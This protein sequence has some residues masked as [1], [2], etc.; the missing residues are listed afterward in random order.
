[1]P[2]P[3]WNAQG[4]VPPIDVLAPASPVRSPYAVPLKEFV[5]KYATSMERRS[6]LRG[7]LQYRL[8][9]H[10]VGLNE[11]F[12]WVNGSF[13]EEVEK[14]EGRP[15]KD[16]DVVTFFTKTTHVDLALVGDLADHA[17]VKQTYKVDGYPLELDLL[18][19]SEIVAHS[20]YWYSM[21]S[22]RRNYMWKGF[23]EIDLAPSEEAKLIQFLNT[24]DNSNGATP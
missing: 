7:Y 5:E 17:F 23:F 12:Q 2:I 8:A 4:V 22:H 13:S 3:D 20:A 16:I 15:P 21:W 18:S 11:G 10:K 1:M 9:W 24:L 14:L 19:P 6:I